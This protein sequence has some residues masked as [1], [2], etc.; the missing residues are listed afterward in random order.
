MKFY[1]K[2]RLKTGTKFNG[3]ML[4]NIT[5]AIYYIMGIMS[6]I[7]EGTG[8]LLSPFMFIGGLLLIIGF[9]EFGIFA[10]LIGICLII[11]YLGSD[12]IYDQFSVDSGA[13]S[14]IIDYSNLVS[15]FNSRHETVVNYIPK[16]MDDDA[17]SLSSEIAMTHYNPNRDMQVKYFKKGMRYWAM[18]YSMSCALVLH[19]IIQA[20]LNSLQQGIFSNSRPIITGVLSSFLAI[21]SWCSLFI[22]A[23]LQRYF[24]ITSCIFTL[25]GLAAWIGWGPSGSAVSA[26]LGDPLQRTAQLTLYLA[27]VLYGTGSLEAPPQNV[28]WA[29]ETWPWLSIGRLISFL[30]LGI[31]ELLWRFLPTTSSRAIFS[32]VSNSTGVCV[33]R[34]CWA[35]GLAGTGFAITTSLYRRNAHKDQNMIRNV[36]QGLSILAPPLAASYINMCAPAMLHNVIHYT[37]LLSGGILIPFATFFAPIVLHSKACKTRSRKWYYRALAIILPLFFMAITLFAMA[38]PSERS[39]FP[40]IVL[41]N[42]SVI[43]PPANYSLTSPT[44]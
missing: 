36:V 42:N 38:V 3:F 43:A 34:I 40:E 17:V 23:T 14:N 35:M 32:Y 31:T 18:G 5:H 10:P 30:A 9:A 20:I 4:K 41:Y 24:K 33:A 12:Y 39:I 6:T 13:P 22:P 29:N 7:L 21:A 37:I 25:V 26:N 11:L 19:C 2:W 16:I 15:V 8:F 27:F 1:L 44:P 28:W